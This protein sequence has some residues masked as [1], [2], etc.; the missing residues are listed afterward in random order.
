M[1]VVLTQFAS[2]NFNRANEDP[3]KSPPW[4]VDSFGDP[5]LQIISDICEAT[6]GSSYNGELYTGTSLPNNQ[7]ASATL[8]VALPA[9][10]GLMV[11][12]RMTDNGVTIPSMSGYMFRVN[13]GGGWTMT[14]G[15]LQ[16]ASG[17]GLTISAGDVYTIAAVNGGI[18]A[19][20]NSTQ[21][22]SVSDATYTS[23]VAA[24][25]LPT[26]GVSPQVSTF[27]IGSAALGATISGN[28]GVAGATVSWAGTSSGSTTADG[29]GNFTTPALVN[30]SYTITP[31][32][33]G[34]TF[35]PASQNETISGSNITGVNFTASNYYSVPD[36]RKYSVFPN[37]PVNVQGTQTYTVPANPSHPAP[38][39]SRTAGAP[40][41]SRVPSIIPENS[42]SPQ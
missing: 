20:Q 9:A 40:T 15:G 27:A 22:D 18:Y 36:D 26:G 10:G 6:A 16:I 37:N 19:F 42:R 3:L 35:S 8:K 11:G 39:D 41:D 13:N 25:V 32:L 7:Y 12:V 21:L 34:H 28:A 5:S 14:A 4:V 24:L 1:T 30:G 33:V 29:S 31:S 23:G 38:V 17:S 2:D